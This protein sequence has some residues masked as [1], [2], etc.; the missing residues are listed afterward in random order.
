MQCFELNDRGVVPGVVVQPDPDPT[1][2]ISANGEFFLVLDKK[3]TPL[4]R[5][6]ERESRGRP[7]RARNLTIV[8]TPEDE[9]V[10]TCR[11][12]K[13][14]LVHLSVSAAPGGKV[15]LSAADDRGQVARGDEIATSFGPFPSLGI[16]VL[17]PQHWK[18]KPW[19][20]GTS[21]LD[22][23][24]V[25]MKGASFRIFRSSAPTGCNRVTYVKWNGAHLD[26][27][28]PMKRGEDEPRLEVT[29]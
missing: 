3:L 8:T 17:G 24:L 22:I 12:T 25:M 26:I 14:A 29:V 19:E 7:I 15:T 2:N 4:V 18:N 23:V 13:E 5:Q 11:P 10:T 20:N 21:H 27:T 28:K 16:S 9:Y 1:I 6:C